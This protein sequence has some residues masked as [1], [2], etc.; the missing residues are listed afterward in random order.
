MF[1]IA[2]RLYFLMYFVIVF[3]RVVILTGFVKQ[4]INLSSKL[5]GSVASLCTDKQAPTGS[6]ISIPTIRNPKYC[7]QEKVDKMKISHLKK[8]CTC[9]EAWVR[10]KPC[11][12]LHSNAEL[13]TQF[14][15]IK[16]L[17]IIS[18]RKPPNILFSV[19]AATIVFIYF[20]DALVWVVWTPYLE[21]VGF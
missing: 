3:W 14:G 16:T 1:T 10:R 8:Q 13:P 21:R 11:T 12:V 5:L 15:K 18:I 4:Q 6:Y 19:R 2:F 17:I 20:T 9:T 7:K